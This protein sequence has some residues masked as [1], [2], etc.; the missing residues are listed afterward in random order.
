MSDIERCAGCGAPLQFVNNQ[1]WLAGGVIAQ[2]NDREHRMV[3]IESDNLDPL[4]R[5]MEEIIGIP[6][7]RIIIETKRRASRE[8]IGRIIP[9]QVKESVRK[10]EMSLDPLIEAVNVIGFVMGYGKSSVVGYRFENDDEDYVT[11][12]K[13]VV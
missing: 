2:A 3:L 13:S 6:L 10:K 4:F 8:Y 9:P 11:D 5:G 12:R 1:V 7:E